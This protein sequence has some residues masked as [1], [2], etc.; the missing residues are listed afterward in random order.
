[1]AKKVDGKV[2]PKLVDEIT[3]QM[4]SNL[5]SIGDQ[6]QR[7]GVNL[8]IDAE[9]SHLQPAVRLLSLSLMARYNRPGSKSIVFNTYQCYLKASLAHLKNDLELAQAMS[10]ILGCKLVRGAYLNSERKRYA[11]DTNG[12]PI[13][14]DYEQTNSS[15]NK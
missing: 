7:H 10:F 14:A 1:M 8:Y 11:Q 9:Y 13:H 2:D 4:E 3:S 6:C 15:Y 5:I 12:F